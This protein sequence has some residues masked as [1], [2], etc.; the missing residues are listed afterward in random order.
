MFDGDESKYE[1]WDV[2]FLGHLRLQKLYDA[3][4]PKDDKSKDKSDEDE[5]TSEDESDEEA[6]D[7]EKN[8]LAFAELAQCLE[9]RSLAL[10]PSSYEKPKMTAEKPWVYYESTTRVR[11]SP[12]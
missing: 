9:D 3:V 7:A 1:L 11:G 5:E 10:V 4:I 6:P 2:K 8:A 12:K